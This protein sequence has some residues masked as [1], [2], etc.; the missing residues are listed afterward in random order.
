MSGTKRFYVI[1]DPI[2]HSLSPVMQSAALAA[3]GLPHTFEARK[4]TLEELPRVLDRVRRG[5]IAGLNVTMPLKVETLRLCDLFT[6][7]V[8]LAGAVNTVWMDATGRLVG[9][10][11]DI[12]GL[13][14]DLLHQGVVPRRVLVLGGGGAAR[15]AVL[16]ASRLGAAVDVATRREEQASLLVRAVGRG[17]SV[18]WSELGHDPT[19]AV[20]DL[21]INAT[22]GG[23]AGGTDGASVADALA[24]ARTTGDAVAYD[25]VYRPPPGTTTTP[26]LAR[27]AEL[28]LRGIDGVGMLVEQGAQALSLFLGA[29][30]DSHVR[31]VMRAAL[32]R[33][34]RGGQPS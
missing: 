26:F 17:T 19:G 31:D 7:D 14:A 5:E 33:A 4:V 32:V 18:L 25:V 23:M 1:G 30:I 13:R 27:A 11:T 12:D 24:R 15:A 20:Y 3:L 6:D 28:G 9:G 16:A 2:G 29:P 21:V 34:L 22:S 10:N 8:S